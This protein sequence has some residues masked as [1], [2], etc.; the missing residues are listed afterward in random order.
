MRQSLLDSEKGR[1][2][3]KIPVPASGD[4]RSGGDFD[5]EGALAREGPLGDQDEQKNEHEHGQDDAFDWPSSEN[6]FQNQLN[7]N[8]L[9][10]LERNLRDEATYLFKYVMLAQVFVYME[11]GALP[12]LLH[13]L[14]HTYFQMDFSMQGLLGGV[15]YLA[16]SAGAPV[17]SYFFQN[18]NP[19]TTMA[20]AL[21]LNNCATVAFAMTPE[22]WPWTLIGARAMIGFVSRRLLLSR[23]FALHPSF[24]V[25]TQCHYC[26]D[27]T[28]LE[29]LPP[30]AHASVPRRLL[31]RLGRSLLPP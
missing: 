22:H 6:S 8:N 7:A 28:P 14:V 2:E 21:L 4:S 26:C 20:T 3:S 13:E 12:A 18:F 27:R 19:K 10:L 1:Q 11:A 24:S 23:S 5:G 29:P 17:A 15:V 31:S 30:Q 25:L 9:S 16:I